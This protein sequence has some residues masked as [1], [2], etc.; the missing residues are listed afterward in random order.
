MNSLKKSSAIKWG[1]AIGLV[2]TLSAIFSLKMLNK[3]EAKN[4]EVKKTM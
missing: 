1:V 3:V 4:D 2:T